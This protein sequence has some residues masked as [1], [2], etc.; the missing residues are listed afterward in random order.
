LW[1]FSAICPFKV[2]NFLESQERIKKSSNFRY[3][4]SRG[5]SVSD[6]NLV[7]YIA[8]NGKSINKVGL[9]V[10][11]KIGKS[12][13]RNRI[14]RLIKEAYRLNK[15]S[16]KKG[17]DLVFIARISSAK[18]SFFDIEKSIKYLMSRSGLFKE[19]EV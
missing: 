7:L 16:F 3:V 4:Y 6:R 8:K 10:S 9:S 5:K 13:T 1:P 17:Y 11:K 2:G 19:G 15:N 18:A 14:R 12:V